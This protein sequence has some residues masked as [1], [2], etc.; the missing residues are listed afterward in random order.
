MQKLSHSHKKG[1]A[2]QMNL[3]VKHAKS[4]VVHFI[5]A[6]AFPPKNFS[7]SVLHEL[8]F[9]DAGC[10]RSLFDTDDWFL[11][12]N[13]WFTRF[14]GTF[15]RGGGQTLFM[16]R[17]L[18][19]KLGGYDESI[20]LMEEYELIQRIKKIGSFNVIQQDVLVSARDYDKH[21]HWKLQAKYGLIYAFFFSGCSQKTM[22]KVYKWLMNK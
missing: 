8:E 18:F 16:E 22:K 14:S 6:D 4:A 15:F 10:F 11:R 1:R 21:G 13:S 7:E 5:H 3:G 19:R 17:D 12:T 20:D 2:V 9:C